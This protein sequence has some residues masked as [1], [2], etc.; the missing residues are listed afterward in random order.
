MKLNVR[1]PKF[2]MALVARSS[3]TKQIQQDG[4]GYD[5]GGV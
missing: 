2:K 5:T 1:I 4:Q 3:G